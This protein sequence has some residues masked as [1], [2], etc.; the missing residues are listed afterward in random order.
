MFNNDN[1]NPMVT[2]CT[3]SGNESEDAGGGMYNAGSSP[4]VTNCWFTENIGSY[5]GGMFNSS[6]SPMV[7]NCL[8]TRNSTSSGSGG[9]MANYNS[10]YGGVRNCTIYD[11]TAADSGGGI[12]NYAGGPTVTNCIVWDN[13]PDQISLESSGTVFTY[14]D[15]QDGTGQSWFGNGCIDVDPNFVDAYNPD[16]NLIDFRLLPVSA[17]I[18]AGNTATV[19]LGVF[20]D[21]DGNPRVVDDPASPDTGITLL[22]VT[23]DMGAYE[24]GPC[25]IEGD[26]NCDGRVDLIDISMLAGNWLYGT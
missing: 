10:S 17:C 18:D 20:V 5:G 2:D 22:G 23:V 1:S 21:M 9:G 24:F 26:I 11:N 8:F 19:L 14:C 12:R 25:V 3:F 16:P 6:S 7:S 15:I 13:V 4:T